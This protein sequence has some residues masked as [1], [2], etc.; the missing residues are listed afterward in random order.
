[1]LIYSNCT[2]HEPIK[3]KSRE[4]IEVKYGMDV[5]NFLLVIFTEIVDL[6][7]R[8]ICLRSPRNARPYVY[9][10]HI[11][12]A[13]DTEEDGKAVLFLFRFFYFFFIHSKPFGDIK[14]KR[15]QRP[16]N[17]LLWTIIMLKKKREKVKVNF[18]TIATTAEFS[19]HREDRSCL[20]VVDIYLS[21]LV[22]MSSV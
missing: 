19:F 12:S 15:R 10:L 14:K 11:L 21:F 6:K 13:V 18:V 20:E 3:C 7:P 17:T 9:I 16:H 2:T 1:M 22:G 5:G 8:S 4:S